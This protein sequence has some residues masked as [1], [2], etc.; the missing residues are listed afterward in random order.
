MIS[1]KSDCKSAVSG[2]V[3]NPFEKEKYRWKT[4]QRLGGGFLSFPPM[5]EYQ[6]KGAMDMN[7][8][9]ALQMLP[10]SRSRTDPDS[11]WISINDGKKR[12]GFAKGVVQGNTITIEFL[13][14]FDEF[15]NRGYALRA[16]EALKSKFTLKMDENYQWFYEKYDSQVEI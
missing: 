2:R 13:H 12:V 15:R 5:G 7:E 14:M 10:R 16:I 11:V 4:L 3:I 9:I 1:I 6:N 8:A